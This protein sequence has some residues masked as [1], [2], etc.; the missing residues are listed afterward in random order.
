MPT[1]AGTHTSGFVA[2]PRRIYDAL[3]TADLNARELRIVLLIVRLTLGAVTLLRQF[4][5]RPT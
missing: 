4:F 5:D 3:L 2:V 1:M